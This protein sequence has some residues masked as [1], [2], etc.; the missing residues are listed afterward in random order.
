MTGT[1]ARRSGPRLLDG[2]VNDR[3]IAAVDVEDVAGGRAGSYWH[4]PATLE[5]YYLA[6][7]QLCSPRPPVDLHDGAWPPAAASGERGP[8][9]LVVDDVGRPAQALNALVCDGAV[10]RGGV[11]MNTIVGPGASIDGG[12]EVEDA[13]LLAGCRVGRHARV[14]RTIVG[15]G[16][17][18]DEG[19]EIGFGDPPPGAHRRASGL[20]VVPG[21]AGNPPTAVA[22]AR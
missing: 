5:E 11:V 14:R 1:A 10:L 13:I 20:T 19:I 18:L 15:A 9:R 12:A 7:M 17:V 22:I 2:L 8:A 4:A 21:A 3:R 6:H 16:A